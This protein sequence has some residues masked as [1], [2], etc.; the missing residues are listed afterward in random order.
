MGDDTLIIWEEIRFSP[1]PEG[2][3]KLYVNT[4]E[5]V[6]GIVR[7]NEELEAAKKEIYINGR[8]ITDRTLLKETR[9]V[10][11]AMGRIQNDFQKV[12]TKEGEEVYIPRQVWQKI[13]FRKIQGSKSGEFRVNLPDRFEI[14]VKVLANGKIIFHHHRRRPRINRKTT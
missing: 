5:D 4:N 3:E 14:R 6:F 12:R 1:P 9:T 8:H 2:I 11:E 10:T 7:T 13:N